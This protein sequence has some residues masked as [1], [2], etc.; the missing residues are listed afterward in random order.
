MQNF[1]TGYANLNEEQKKAVDHVDG[2]LLVL[3]GPG[4]G[5]TQL[6]SLRAAQILRKTEATAANILCLTYT[7]KAAINMRE[8]LLAL[9]GPEANAITVK[10]FHSFA[11]DIINNYPSYFWNGATLRPIPQTRQLEIIEELLSELPLSHPMALKFAGQYTLVDTVIKAIAITKEA[12]LT[13]EKLRSILKIN[14]AYIEEIEEE[15]ASILEPRLSDKRYPEIIE[16]ISSLKSMNIGDMIAPL[17]PLD[18]ILKESFEYAMN[19]Q[20]AGKKGTVSAWKSKW[21]TTVDGKKTMLRERNRNTWWL[22]L[23][24]I[25]E[26]YQNKSQHYG[27][28]DLSDLIIEVIQA[29]EHTPELRAD[30]QEQFTHVMIDEFQDTNIAQGRLSHLIADHYT[31]E[32]RPNIMAVGDDDQTIYRFQGAELNN[33]RSFIDLYG[34]EI[35][36]LTKNYRSSQNILDFSKKVIEKAESRLVNMID[37]LSKNLQ[38]QSDVAGTITYRS[39]ETQAQQYQEVVEQAK[40]LSRHGTVAILA[41]KHQSLA[42]LTPFFLYKNIAISYEQQSNL[43]DDE[44]V[45]LIIQITGIAVALH[46]GD[47]NT[48]DSLISEMLRHAAWGIEPK[49]LWELS[50]N[51]R[52]RG[53]WLT[54]VLESDDVNIASIGHWLLWLSTIANREPAIVTLEYIIGLKAGEHMT[55]PIIT[56][57]RKKDIMLR[58]LSAL[59]HFKKIV[60]EHSSQR[61]TLYDFHIMMDR[62]KN[63]NKTLTDTSVYVSSS[64]NIELLTVHKSKG[65]EFASVII[66]D[67][68]DKHWSP[69]TR[70]AERTPPSNLPL[71]RNGDDSDDFAR[72]MYVAMTRAKKNILVTNFRVNDTNEP[73]MPTILLNNVLESESVELLHDLSSEEQLINTIHWPRLNPKDEFDLLRPILDEYQLSATHLTTFLN[74]A[75][76]GPK[77][78]FEKNLLRIPSPHNDKMAF[79][80]AVHS[81]L[82][83]AQL[84]AKDQNFNIG[85][86]INDFEIAL[87]EEPMSINAYN[88]YLVHGKD[89]IIRLFTTL[90]FS[91]DANALAEQKITSVLQN[92]V[93]LTGKLDVIHNDKSTVAFDDYK[94]GKPVANINS[95]AKNSIKAWSQ[96]YQITFYNILLS[97]SSRYAGKTILPANMIYVESETTKDL[98]QSYLPDVLE[99]QKVE[100]LINIVWQHIA[101]LNFPETRHYEPTYKGIMKFCDDLLLGTI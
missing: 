84:D 24:D 6:L 40:E 26:L 70:N 53:N 97:R 36:I 59:N 21:L 73:Q 27:F 90:D 7:N 17:R 58:S 45:N 47:V 100:K 14:I 3:A 74:V 41:R 43:L 83:K 18:E 34:A 42:G 48:S 44:V 71:K 96:R 39:Y 80:R 91:L 50:I 11:A 37:G 77:Y 92:N 15:L 62:L 49:T 101:E 86:C 9:I 35:I 87:N 56:Y 57:L 79:G 55:S 78:F 38:A 93:R 13:A 89:V 61:A 52:N 10:T 65:L 31:S 1:E 81:A 16:K 76:G 46:D 8:R 67:A 51:N 28:Y 95:Q 32:G 85:K 69:K 29:V 60:M 64:N 72:L 99:I 4:T 19:Q 2:P 63:N 54:S 82:E 88:R 25:Y 75:H 33:M 98:M 20:L 30:L 66:I 12:G 22:A 68:I 94:T 23:C 5:K